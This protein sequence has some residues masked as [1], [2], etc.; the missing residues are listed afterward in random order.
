MGKLAFDTNDIKILE[1]KIDTGFY[2][3]PTTSYKEVVGF[4]IGMFQYDSEKRLT[5]EELSKHDFLSKNIRH[6]VRIENT[7]KNYIKNDKLVISIKEDKTL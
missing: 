1:Q 6:F 2:S 5:A 3:L 7:V 4:L